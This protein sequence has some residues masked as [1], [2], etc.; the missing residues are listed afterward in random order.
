VTTFNKTSKVREQLQRLPIN[1]SLLNFPLPVA[2]R[3]KGEK[4]YEK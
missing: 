2:T 4:E 3:R 1:Y